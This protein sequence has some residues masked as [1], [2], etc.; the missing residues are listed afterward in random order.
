M[1]DQPIN[2]ALLDA[3]DWIQRTG[4]PTRR[5]DEAMACQIFDVWWDGVRAQG[6]QQDAD[7]RASLNNALHRAFEARYEKVATDHLCA[8]FGA[9]FWIHTQ[10]RQ[11]ASWRHLEPPKPPMPD[12]NVPRP[13]HLKQGSCSAPSAPTRVRLDR[14]FW[15]RVLIGLP[16][17]ASLT[18]LM[19]IIGWWL[20]GAP[21]AS[22]PS[23]WT[24][25]PLM[26][27][28]WAVMGG[29]IALLSIGI[30]AVACWIAFALGASVLGAVQSWK[31]LGNRQAR[32]P[33]QK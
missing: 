8:V 7:R 30:A 20:P 6:E 25:E 9:A 26:P 4:W 33:T 23:H 18:F 1:Q 19:A 31:V 14:R 13:N 12:D 21:A 27:A 15:I 2:E 10:S 3:I 24:A 17:L 11:S 29:I 5:T 32:T 28:G 16:L 22:G